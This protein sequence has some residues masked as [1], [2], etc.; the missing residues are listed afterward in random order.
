M[1]GIDAGAMFD[2]EIQGIKPAGWVTRKHQ[3]EIQRKWKKGKEKKRVRG[4]D[5]QFS[6]EE[7]RGKGYLFLLPKI[8]R[9]MV[10]W[11]RTRPR[12]AGTVPAATG[13][14]NKLSLF[15]R[16]LEAPGT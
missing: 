10:G 4:L 16:S 1:Y 3:Q 7:R 15:L 14:E 12:T 9:P 5:R 13:A 11:L 6:K 8:Y 2:V